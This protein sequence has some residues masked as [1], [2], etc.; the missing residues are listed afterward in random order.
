MIS[1]AMILEKDPLGSQQHSA[2]AGHLP[3]TTRYIY[4]NRE[5]LLCLLC[6][7]RRLPCEIIRLIFEH[8]A[9]ISQLSYDRSGSATC[10]VV[11]LSAT[12]ASWRSIALS[13]SF[14]WADV[15]VRIPNIGTS[16]IPLLRAISVFSARSGSS[17]RTIRIISHSEKAARSSKILS[18]LFAHAHRCRSL[19][20]SVPQFSWH[21]IRINSIFET[22]L[23]FPLLESLT[24]SQELKYLLENWDETDDLD[25]NEPIHVPLGPSL[26]VFRTATNLTF[27]HLSQCALRD[28][29]PSKFKLGFSD[30]LS[31][32]V[33]TD[34]CMGVFR[35]LECCANLTT[36]ELYFT[37]AT[38]SAAPD[39]LPDHLDAP[40]QLRKLE[41]ILFK[42][43]DYN[44]SHALLQAYIENFACPSLFSLDVEMREITHE[45]AESYFTRHYWPH[46]F[47]HF[48]LCHM[49]ETS[50]CYPTKLVLTRISLIDEDLLKLL[51]YLSELQELV[52][53]EH[54]EISKCHRE[55]V[56]SLPISWLFIESLRGQGA[57]TLL[58]RLRKLS[59]TIASPEFDDAHLLDVISSR[60]ILSIDICFSKRA[61]DM[62]IT[63]HQLHSLLMAGFPYRLSL[64]NGTIPIY[65]WNHEPDIKKDQKTDPG[66][67]LAE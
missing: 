30:R 66:K 46:L 56:P 67:Y 40:V 55:H 23:D 50:N 63:H 59:L 27:L 17:F 35:V 15:A 48:E 7:A 29:D 36:L 47:P 33:L 14:L 6:P 54:P 4:C 39:M 31:T 28:I 8:C 44:F 13:C 61:M 2:I 11:A 19:Q 21:A 51:E 58:P 34:C 57:G 64:Y 5:M 65:L 38:I 16:S 24:I 18:R 26:E 42:S 43:G 60:Q 20:I 32:L 53:S 25:E 41:H 12:C 3:R 52:I 22:K 49:I 9:T 37:K 62:D 10:T 45:E 1:A